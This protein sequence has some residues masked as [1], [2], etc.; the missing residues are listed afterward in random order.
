MDLH[1][2]AHEATAEETE[3]IDLC[4]DKYV[5]AD[6]GPQ[7]ILPVLH[8][9]QGR[10]GWISPGALNLACR[11]LQMPPAEAFGVADFYALFQTRPHPPVTVHVCDDIGCRFKGGED[12]CAEMEKSLGPGAGLAPQPLP[13]PLR[14]RAGRVGDDRRQAAQG[15]GPR[16]DDRRADRGRHRG[17][18]PARGSRPIGAPARPAGA[19]APGPRGAGRP[20]KPGRLPGRRRLPGP[21][22]GFRDG[23][24]AR[25]ARGDR[26][27]ARGPRRRRVPHRAEMA[28]RPLGAAAALPRLQRG[29][30]R[31]RHLQGPRAHGARSVSR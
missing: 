5:L 3:A 18:I 13:R 23:T 25:G 31:A 29:R 4:L 30:V 27:Q 22:P 17:P 1:F 7:H 8:A 21:A 16:P 14:A 6:H 12:L 9:I 26:F 19:Q 20:R 15:S 10:V 24:R 28:G 11:R 2:T